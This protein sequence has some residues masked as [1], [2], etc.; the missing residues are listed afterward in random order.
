M[1]NI[2]PG[3]YTHD[4]LLHSNDDEVITG[5]RAFVERGLETG[6]RVLVHGTRERVAMMRDV[7]G[8]PPGLEYGF[9]EELYQAPLQTLFAYQRAMAHSQDGAD[10]WA[11]GT[12]PMSPEP[13]GHAAWGRYE[14]LVN[15]ALGTYAF[16]GLCTYDTTLLSEDAI[17]AAKT[18]HPSV[19][20]GVRRAPSPD[21]EPP[22]DFLAD[23]L[24]GVPEVPDGRPALSMTVTGFHHLRLA[25]RLIQ[26]SSGSAEA[27]S[28]SSVEG[29]IAAVNEVLVNGVQHGGRPVELAL[30]V[31]RTRLVCQVTDSGS[32]SVDPLA[33]YQYPKL[34][35]PSGLWVARQLC[36]DIFI[37]NLPGGGSRVLLFSQ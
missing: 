22:A 8:S 24:A 26:R 19:T 11:T 20:S 12:V 36:D 33:G 15:E 27:V 9:D 29:F 21:Y 16:H 23:P 32:G 1:K 13:G 30:W 34:G 7:F 6:G 35:G 31:E 14:S 28:R 2:T 17:A 4:V 10:L 3:S 5:T 37:S 18:S 25:R